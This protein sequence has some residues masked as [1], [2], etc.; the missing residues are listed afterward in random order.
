MTSTTI[1]TIAPTYLYIK[2][3][4]VTGLKYFGKTNRDPY[5]YL[6]SGKYWTRHI[7]KYGKEHVV[8]LWVSELYTNK[9]LLT[10]FALFFSEEYNIVESKEW[11][12]LIPENGLTG[13][14]SGSGNHMYGKKGEDHPNYGKISPTRIT[15]SLDAWASFTNEQRADRELKRQN[16]ISERTQEQQ[17]TI[18]KKISSM[19][20][21]TKMP[22]RSD[23]HLLKLSL[24]NGKNYLVTSPEGEQF[25]ICSLSAF[26]KKNNLHN[27]SMSEV[28]RGK[29]KH[30]KGWLCIRLPD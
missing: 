24:A 10:E 17:D 9:E 30:Y 23:E 26:C 13:A 20:L 29:R 14:L 28:S 4:S 5:K 22:T 19:K 25:Q 11:A 2:Q 15:S 1:Y 12:N 7:K 8:T 6:G 3:H 18:N 21:G 27:S 16:T